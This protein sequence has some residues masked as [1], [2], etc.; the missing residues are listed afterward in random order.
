M[1]SPHLSQAFVWRCGAP[2]F[3]KHD[4]KNGAY[5]G[6]I[7]AGFWAGSPRQR[8]RQVKGLSHHACKL[9]TVAW[10]GQAVSPAGRSSTQADDG[11]EMSLDT[12]RV[13]ACAT[14]KNGV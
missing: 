8:A 3:Q 7:A 10:M 6:R 12:A 9:L 5:R 13:G 14:T 4:R 2:T 11:V 1:V